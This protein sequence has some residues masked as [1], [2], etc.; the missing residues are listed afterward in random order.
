MTGIAAALSGYLLKPMN[1]VERVISIA[2]G[3]M[4]IIPGTSTDLIGIALVA[5][6]VVLQFIGKKRAAA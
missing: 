6:A 4:L 3:L 5:V 1:I 2:G